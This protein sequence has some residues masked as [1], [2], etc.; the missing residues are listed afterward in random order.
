MNA[1][2]YLKDLFNTDNLSGIE[3]EV[4]KY[5]DTDINLKVKYN[6][7]STELFIDRGDGTVYVTNLDDELEEIGDYDDLENINEFL[8]FNE[9]PDC[10][11]SGTTICISWGQEVQCDCE[12]NNKPFKI[13]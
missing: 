13:G 1:K 4:V 5:P 10:Q 12:C 8:L 11:D 9:C 2:S 7:L 3:F 6:H